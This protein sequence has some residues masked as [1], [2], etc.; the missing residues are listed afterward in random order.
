MISM[1]QLARHRADAAQPFDDLCIGH[2]NLVRTKRTDCK[3]ILHTD[4]DVHNVPPAPHSS[5]MADESIGAR[6]RAMQ[7]RSGLTYDQ[8]AK[9]A[10]Y[11]GRS[12]V[13]RYFDADFDGPLSPAVCAKLVAGFEGSGVD[14][15]EIWALGD[16]PTPNAVPTATPDPRP[17]E[18]RGTVPIYGTALGAALDFDSV[19]IEQTQLDQSDV[20]GYARRPAALEGRME[21]YAVYIQGSSMAPRF[22]EGEMALVDPKRPPQIGDDVL[23]FLRSPEDDGERITACLIKRLVRRT[24]QYVELEQFT[25]ATTFRVSNDMVAGVQRVIPWSELLA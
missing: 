11:N 5:A 1:A 17:S 3:S 16:F 19:C 18:R 12:S 13:Q 22:Q 20:I 14:A 2:D 24:A 7:Q 21:I 15:T 4:Y 8:I 6:L 9:K 25:P 10:G 23:V